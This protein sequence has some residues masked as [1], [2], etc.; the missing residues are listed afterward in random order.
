M[1]LLANGM[2]VQVES[3]KEIK[4]KPLELIESIKVAEFCT[5]M[6]NN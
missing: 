3:C 2:I 6:M 1:S 5:L 4:E